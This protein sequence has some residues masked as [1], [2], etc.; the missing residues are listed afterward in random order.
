MVLPIEGAGIAGIAAPASTQVDHGAASRKVD[1]DD[2]LTDA[3]SRAGSAERSAENA[4]TRFADGDPSIGIH[5]VVIAA[6]EA[7]FSLRYAT[8][9]KNKVLEAYREIMNTQV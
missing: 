5:E 4:S 3:F 8:T 7:N 1:F 6:E 2:A 9:L